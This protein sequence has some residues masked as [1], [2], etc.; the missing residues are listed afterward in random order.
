[1]AL[2]GI[3]SMHH[4]AHAGKAGICRI[5]MKAQEL[6]DENGRPRDPYACAEDYLPSPKKLVRLEIDVEW[7]RI[8]HFLNVGWKESARVPLESA[9]EQHKHQWQRQMEEI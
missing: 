7:E 5:I 9:S 3:V 2:T 1:M 8:H 4:M 6:D